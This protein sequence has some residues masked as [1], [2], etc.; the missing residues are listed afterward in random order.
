ME[1]QHMGMILRRAMLASAYAQCSIESFVKGSLASIGIG[2]KRCHPMWV[3]GTGACRR[4]SMHC[5]GLNR[6]CFYAASSG[7]Q[8]LWQ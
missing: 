1:G 3:G 2:T 6:S 4:Y 7:C 5:R 8:P